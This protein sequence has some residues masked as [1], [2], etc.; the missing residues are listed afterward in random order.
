VGPAA[1]FQAHK[2]CR[3]NYN[4]LRGLFTKRQ[5]IWI[6]PDLI[7]NEKIHGPVP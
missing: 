1:I 6:F 2:D 7:S 4:N 3:L 5:G